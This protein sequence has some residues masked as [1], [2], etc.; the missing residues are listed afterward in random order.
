[1]QKKNVKK[2]MCK[3]GKCHCSRLGELH[4]LNKR[5]V[6]LRINRL[7]RI[8]FNDHHNFNFVQ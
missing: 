5:Q 1:M 6:T 8:A 4:F 2:R 3:K 7:R